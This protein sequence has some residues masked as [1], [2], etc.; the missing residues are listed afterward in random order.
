MTFLLD[1]NVCIAHLRGTNNGVTA[2][3]TD[4]G[5]GEVTL[6]LVVKVELVYG[7]ERSSN[8]DRNYEQLQRF[9]VQFR[10]LPFDDSAAAEYGSIRAELESQGTPIGPNDLMIAAIALGYGLTLV[11][12]NMSEFSRVPGLSLEDWQLG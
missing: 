3:L 2:R 8:P 4:A 10:S 6:C 1:T 5:P 9:F 7:V 12:H 11:T